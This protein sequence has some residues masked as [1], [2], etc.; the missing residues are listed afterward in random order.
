MTTGLCFVIPNLFLDL[1]FGFGIYV[2]KPRPVG[3]VTYLRYALRQLMRFAQWFRKT[4]P[5]AAFKNELIA[6]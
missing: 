4:K 3:G 5:F 1:G 6:R 2:L